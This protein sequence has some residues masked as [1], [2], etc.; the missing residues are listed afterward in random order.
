MAGDFRCGYYHFSAADRFGLYKAYKENKLYKA[1]LD[2]LVQEPTVEEEGTALVTALENRREELLNAM[3]KICEENPSLDGNYW[4]KANKNPAFEGQMLPGKL[5][6]EPDWHFLLLNQ[7]WFTESPNGFFLENM[8][9]YNVGISYRDS[10]AMINPDLY[11]IIYK[12]NVLLTD[13]APGF[14]L[15]HLYAFSVEQIEEV[16]RSTQ[17]TAVDKK[18]EM[19]AYRK[20]LDNMEIALNGLSRRTLMTNEEMQLTG[21]SSM[22]EYIQDELVR[23]M[24]EADY[25]SK[26]NAW[27][28]YEERTTYSKGFHGLYRVILYNC[29][30][31]LV[32]QEE[33]TMGHCAAIL[34]PRQEQ[35]MIQ[36]LDE[37]EFAYLLWRD[38][39]R[40]RRAGN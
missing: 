22:E 15:A 9:T 38:N 8:Q 10:I 31:V 16:T 13:K 26:I 35:K 14:V 27:G 30:D 24:Y 32:S 7:P 1:E 21:R 12:N 2:R 25:E 29:A 19:D 3:R 5:P 11:A 28:D 36:I 4:W 23:G 40:S 20:K 34:V 18:A 6:N 37:Y 39:P 17:R 33:K